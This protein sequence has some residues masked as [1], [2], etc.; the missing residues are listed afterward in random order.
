MG[1]AL[2]TEPCACRCG[3]RCGGPGRCKLDVFDCLARDD[4]QHF[5]VDCRHDWSGPVAESED[6]CTS[7][8]TCATCGMWRIYHDTAAGP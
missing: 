1:A 6:R 7:S 3:Y 2:A 8:V 5:V 4:G